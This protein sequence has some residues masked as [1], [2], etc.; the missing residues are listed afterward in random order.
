MDA[1]PTIFLSFSTADG[2]DIAE[3][4]YRHYKRKGYNV[5]LS[6]EEIPYGHKW[7]EE[8]K[9]QVCKKSLFIL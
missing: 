3:H 9:K 8:I 5:F 2:G 1:M 7:R 4:V 6:I